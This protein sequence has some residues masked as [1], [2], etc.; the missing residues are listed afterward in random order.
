MKTIKKLAMTS[1]FAGLAV[2]ATAQQSVGVGNLAG[3][4]EI[5]S[6]SYAIGIA[7]AQGLKEYA[8]E[9]LDVD[10]DRFR[11]DF[12]SGLKE[13]VRIAK[14]TSQH[15]KVSGEMVGMQVGQSM[16][17]QINTAFFDSDSTKSISIDLMVKAMCDV[18]NG[19]TLMDAEKAEEFAEK[20][21]TSMR[22]ERMLAK[23]GD[24]KKAGEEF[25]R[26]NAKKK[27][28]KKLEDGVQYKVLK[29]GNGPMPKEED[30]VR[31]HYEGR[32]IDGNVFDSSYERDE[33]A[34]FALTDVV[35][36][37]AIG[38][39]HMPVGSI[40]EVYIPQEQAYGEREAGDIKPFSTLIFKVELLE[41]NPE[42]SDE[43]EE[44]VEE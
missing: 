33:P 34:T 16:V 42:E 10:M 12:I 15:A 5:D 27:G 23:Y 44:E 40:W 2:T 37:F 11:E 17:N 32:T 41:I 31:V 19:K 36:G 30:R 26:K 38:L 3:L 1:L 14:G 21:M 28:V 13:A 18:L 29:A 35:R 22:M 9:S 39:E 4:S 8:T 25:L 43:E 20:K 7:Q 6:L 24:N